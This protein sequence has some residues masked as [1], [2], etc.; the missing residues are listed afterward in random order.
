MQFPGEVLG[1]I[2]KEVAADAVVLQVQFITLIVVVADGAVKHDIGFLSHH[3][4]DK[5]RDCCRVG[6]ERVGIGRYLHQS[7]SPPHGPDAVIA[8][9]ELRCDV[10]SQLGTHVHIGQARRVVVNTAQVGVAI[11]TAGRVL[12]DCGIQVTDARAV[13]A[14]S[15]GQFEAVG[16]IKLVT[17]AGTGYPVIE[18]SVVGLLPPPGIG[19]AQI[20][21]FIAQSGTGIPRSASEGVAQ[22]SGTH[23]GH[24]LVAHVGISINAEIIEHVVAVVQTKDVLG[25][26]LDG[27]LLSEWTCPVKL[28]GVLVEVLFAVLVNTVVRH[29]HIH[30]V[31]IAGVVFVLVAEGR[32]HVTQCDGL[33]LEAGAV[34]VVHTGV[35]VV[36]VS[37][38]VVVHTVTVKRLAGSIPHQ[39]GVD[40]IAGIIVGKATQ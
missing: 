13:D 14:C 22:V 28:E 30:E 37:L 34:L 1:D 4:L 10:K 12:D 40:S 8:E 5:G 3:P 26:G 7:V 33:A 29:W 9:L 23:L 25:T 17:Q 18:M 39:V 32:E 20:A 35:E 38:G 19:S 21:V 36:T 27:V 11:G 16:K 15:I 31:G 6:L 2:G 24:M